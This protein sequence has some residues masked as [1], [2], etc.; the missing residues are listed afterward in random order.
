MRIRRYVA[1][2][3]PAAVAQ[4]K[5]DLGP[6]AVILEVRRVRAP[7]LTGW[8]RPRRVEVT[9]AGGEPNARSEAPPVSSGHAFAPPASAPPSRATWSVAATT[10]F[11]TEFLPERL[12]RPYALA[13]EQVNNLVRR[14][15]R[16]ELAQELV[17][18]AL[19]SVPED[20]L[21]DG[22]ALSESLRREMLRLFPSRPSEPLSGRVFAFIGPTGVGK[23]TT[24][25]KLAAVYSLQKEKRVA[26]LTQ[27]TYRIAAVDQLKRY[28]EI[29]RLPLEVLFTPDDL[30]RALER[31]GQADLIL[32]DTAGRSPKQG[33]HLAELRTF[34][35]RCP[36]IKTVLVVSATTKPEDLEH[37]FERFQL[38]HPSQLLLTKLDE[39]TS[40]GSI[41]NLMARA[42]MPVGYITNGQN[43]PDD[44]ELASPERLV[45]LI[46]G[47]TPD[48]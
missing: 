42:R 41:L 48:A 24:I 35:A 45:D 36:E 46:L 3:L 4:V 7:G 27:D 14:G 2:S 22:A 13:S 44:V 43:V 33:M 12:R 23:T 37:V 6:E 20:R 19:A 47:G 8:F 10:F 30:P 29:L 25:A 21:A 40:V 26:I 1:A 15:V 28:A 34:L 16:L 31:H 32:L 11:P 17:E 18:R 5:K 38:L 9:A 39:T